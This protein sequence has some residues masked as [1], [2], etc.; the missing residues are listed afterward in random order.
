[1]ANAR[2]SLLSV[3]GALR[4]IDPKGRPLPGQCPVNFGDRVRLPEWR[5]NCH[6]ARAVLHL[7]VQLGSPPG[8]VPHDPSGSAVVPQATLGRTASTLP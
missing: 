2:H 1:M 6:R 5:I 7:E 8:R 4:L 3:R